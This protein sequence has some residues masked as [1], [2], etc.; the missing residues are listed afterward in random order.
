MRDPS[1][2]DVGE[3]PLTG[4]G[5]DLAAAEVGDRRAAAHVVH[6]P[7]GRRS[8]GQAAS[9]YTF[10]YYLGASVFG[11]LGAKVWTSVGW[12]GVVALTV[13]LLVITDALALRLRVTRSLLA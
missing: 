5:R 13:T 8:A 1:N 3:H 4:N 2:G 9:L 6:E 12:W 10:T 11:T 7:G